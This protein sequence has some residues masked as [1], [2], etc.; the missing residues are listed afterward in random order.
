M[1]HAAN[2]AAGF[3]SA[4]VSRRPRRISKGN[5]A[6]YAGERLMDVTCIIATKNAARFLGAALESIAK[7]PGVDPDVVVVDG[8][9]TDSTREI[10]RSFGARVVDEE[11]AGLANAWN[12]G[13]RVAATPLIAFLDSDDLWV[14][15]TLARR[16]A[17]LETSGA[18]VSF[19][20]VRHFV[21]SGS[22]PPPEFARLLRSD[23]ELLAPIPGTMLVYRAVFDEIG[24]FNP[25]FALAADVDWLGR[26]M[27]AEIAT[28]KFDGLVLLKRLHGE[29]LTS[30]PDRVHDE[31][32]AA[33][34]RKLQGSRNRSA[35]VPSRQ[36][37]A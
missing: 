25:D 36:R 9:S 14:A 26:M 33:L 10:A 3:R 22:Q 32:L 4:G 1:R 15:D 29:N 5:I 18:A 30:R 24:A 7:Q 20:R 23:A 27:R 13:I 37:G 2:A 19:G 12:T 28:T 6:R 16:I 8:A 17:D 34:R 21:D 35:I 31:L 11:S